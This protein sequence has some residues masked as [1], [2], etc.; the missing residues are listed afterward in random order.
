MREIWQTMKRLKWFFKQYWLKYLFCLLALIFVSV[1]PVVPAKVLGIAI[2]DIA[3]GTI[4]LSRIFLCILSKY[5]L[6]LYS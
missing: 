4:S 6:P 5:L 2:D 1:M 3:M